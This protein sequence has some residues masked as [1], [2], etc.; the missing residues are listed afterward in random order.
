MAHDLP[1]LVKNTF[2]DLDDAPRLPGLERSRSEPNRTRADEASD[3]EESDEEG[4]TSAENGDVLTST[5]LPSPDI[6]FDGDDMAPPEM[7]DLYRT[8]TCDGYEP[9]YHWNWLHGDQPDGLAPA[10]APA[11]VAMPPPVDA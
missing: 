10:P 7:S 6:D 1:V 5:P 4:A 3:D 8:T 9:M 2:L 11:R